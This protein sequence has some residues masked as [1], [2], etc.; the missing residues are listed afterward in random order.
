M[1]IAR[2][3]I[4]SAVVFNKLTCIAPQG[5]SSYTRNSQMR[6]GMPG[7]PLCVT[8]SELPDPNSSWKGALFAMWLG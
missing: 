6:F 3:A 4:V 2:T 1:W 8:V 5:W 7:K